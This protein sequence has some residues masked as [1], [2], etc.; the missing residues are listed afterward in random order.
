MNTGIAIVGG[1]IGGL[2]M[3][4]KL[5]ERGYF[6]WKLY[7]AADRFGGKIHSNIYTDEKDKRLF[8]EWGAMRFEWGCQPHL[9]QL[10]EELNL[11]L[12]EFPPFCGAR[13]WELE[14]ID[15]MCAGFWKHFFKYYDIDPGESVWETLR[16]NDLYLR[17]FAQLGEESWL[18]FRGA[19][20]KPQDVDLL[21]WLQAETPDWH[22]KFLKAATTVRAF[23]GIE[24]NV[25]HWMSRWTKVMM[26]NNQI[27]TCKNGNESIIDELVRRLPRR[28][29]VDKMELVR[30]TYHPYDAKKR[31]ELEFQN[32]HVEFA[33]KV[34]LALPPRQLLQLDFEYPQNVEQILT[35]LHGFELGRIFIRIKNPWWQADSFF[36]MQN[37]NADDLHAREVYYYTLSDDEG[38]IMIYF[39]KHYMPHWRQFS[40]DEQLVQELA[41]LLKVEKDRIV[42]VR[43]RLWDGKSHVYAFQYLSNG[44]APHDV[45]QKFSTLNDNSLAILGDTY[46]FDAGFI[47][48][49]LTSCHYYLDRNPIELSSSVAPAAVS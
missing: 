11:E 47:E 8:C 18:P 29:L 42:D 24:F 36:A 19:K 37:E 25:L 35:S 16:T 10:I 12:L 49:V 7:N 31:Y 1:G 3:G 46:S 17:F 33:D 26:A 44:Y 14:L 23:L 48:G 39:G 6:D 30:L 21:D 13:G 20:T 2:Y 28:N 32:G 34:I 40:T 4:Y 27:K 45:M 43:Y 22:A 38:V 9:E 5:Q 15:E 41:R